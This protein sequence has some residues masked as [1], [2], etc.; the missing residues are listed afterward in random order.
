MGFVPR[1]EIA[2][3]SLLKPLLVIG[4]LSLSHVGIFNRLS[5]FDAPLPMIT[6]PC[7]ASRISWLEASLHAETAVLRMREY[8]AQLSH[9]LDRSSHAIAEDEAGNVALAGLR[10]QLVR[11]LREYQLF[12]HTEI[13]DP[14]I[15]NV[16]ADRVRDA[17]SMKDRCEQIGA[18]YNSFIKAWHLGNGGPSSSGYRAA[19]RRMLDAVSRHVATEGE[20]IPHLLRGIGE[21]K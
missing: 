19:A 21:I 4:R 11:A 12:K 7:S 6:R 3:G 9:L 17:T 18:Q 15:R 13:F 8:H 2:A 10:W 1:S 16:A 20:Q 14:L 5:D